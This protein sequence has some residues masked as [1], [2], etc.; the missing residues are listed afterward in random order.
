MIVSSIESFQE[1][2]QDT[3]SALV[4]CTSRADSIPL[5]S[6]SDRGSLEDSSPLAGSWRLDQARV[7][8]SP[9]QDSAR[10]QH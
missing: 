10:E 1:S 6:G 3:Q 4:L 9:R 7:P 2:F 5:A 8:S